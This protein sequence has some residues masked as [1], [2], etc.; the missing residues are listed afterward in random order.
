LLSLSFGIRLDALAALKKTLTNKKRACLA[1][2]TRPRKN[3]AVKQKS[4]D[5]NFVAAHIFFSLFVPVTEK[6][7]TS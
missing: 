4:H 2:R 1:L 5:E 6:S 3:A 7:V